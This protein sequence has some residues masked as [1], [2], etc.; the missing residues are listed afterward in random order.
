MHRCLPRV[1]RLASLCA[2]A[3]LALGASSAVAAPAVAGASAA[4]PTVAKSVPVA[5]AIK[6]KRHKKARGI[7]KWEASIPSR[8]ER[9]QAAGPDVSLVEQPWAMLSVRAPV[10]TTGTGNSYYTALSDVADRASLA[11]VN[12]EFVDTRSGWAKWNPPGGI[13]LPG[14]FPGSGTSNDLADQLACSLLGIGCDD[15]SD[16]TPQVP[17]D[18]HLWVKAAAGHNY[19]AVCRVKF[20]NAVGDLEIVSGETSM[21]VHLDHTGSSSTTVSFV[22]DPDAAGWHGVA[23]SSAEGWSTTGCTVDEQ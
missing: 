15:G 8:A 1:A 3:C 7:S 12:P 5:K 23:I 20:D 11:F 19:L 22:I 9:V 10:A 13:S 18:L 16:G 17:V 21:S 4:K 14:G 2:V 6:A